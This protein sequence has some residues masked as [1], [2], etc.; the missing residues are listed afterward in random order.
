MSLLEAIIDTRRYVRKECLHCKS[1]KLVQQCVKEGQH[2]YDCS[3]CGRRSAI[4]HDY[5]RRIQK[6]DE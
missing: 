2:V 5:P 3:E 1:K 6:H 4:T